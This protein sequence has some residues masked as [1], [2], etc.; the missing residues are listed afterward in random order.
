LVP[1]EDPEKLASAINDLLTNKEL[2]KRLSDAGY[3]F[4]MK[5][6]TWDALLPKY[7]KFYEDLLK[8]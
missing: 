6:L 7:I 2:A 1:P 5:N 3:D 8:N 4:V